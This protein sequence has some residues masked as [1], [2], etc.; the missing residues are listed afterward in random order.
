MPR[1]EKLI[2]PENAKRGFVSTYPKHENTYTHAHTSI[3][4]F[5]E[6]KKP[7]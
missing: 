5:V 1:L 4:H 6:F 3:K 2:E 7:Y